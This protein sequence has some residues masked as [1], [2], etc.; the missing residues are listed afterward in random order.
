MQVR[1]STRVIALS[2]IPTL[3][4]LIFVVFEAARLGF[5]LGWAVGYLVA[6]YYMAEYLETITLTGMVKPDPTEDERLLAGA[7]TLEGRNKG[8]LAGAVMAAAG[9]LGATLLGNNF[10]YELASGA[11][12]MATST[13][14]ILGLA[15][16][17][18]EKVYAGG[19]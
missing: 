3:F 16:R 18:L 14:L 4:A 15:V 1:Y 12:G 10:L 17:R 19:G 6:Q 9:F 7:V 2:A 13:L 5:L 11:G 8:A